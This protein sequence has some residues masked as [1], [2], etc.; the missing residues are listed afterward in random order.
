VVA[1]SQGLSFGLSRYSSERIVESKFND[2]A[3]RAYAR[4]WR[5]CDI[6]PTGN[7]RPLLE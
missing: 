5:L 2:D 7:E 1:H 4:L 6:R 3:G